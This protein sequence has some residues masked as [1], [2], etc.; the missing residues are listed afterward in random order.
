MPLH[1]PPGIVQS[2]HDS[3]PG[4]A[5]SPSSASAHLP[6]TREWHHQAFIDL[7]LLS[8][9]SSSDPTALPEMS[10]LVSQNPAQVSPPHKAVFRAHPLCIC[11]ESYHHTHCLSAPSALASCPVPCSVRALC[12]HSAGS[13]LHTADAN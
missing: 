10:S 7:P 2:P 4:L 5:L 8:G 13:V 1:F 12:I 9:A 6:A 3:S 11:T